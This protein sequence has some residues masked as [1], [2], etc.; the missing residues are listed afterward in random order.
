MICQDCNRDMMDGVSCTLDSGWRVR[1]GQETL[2]A[3]R[4][5]FAAQRGEA[6]PFANPVPMDDPEADWFFALCNIGPHVGERE[7]PDCKTPVGGVHHSGCDTEECPFCH[8][9]AIG[10]ECGG[11]TVALA[12]A[13][14]GGT[15]DMKV[16]ADEFARLSASLGHKP[17]DI[18]RTV[19]ER[20]P[21]ADAVRVVE[22][23]LAWHN[24]TKDR[25]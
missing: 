23:A 19:S 22:R 13:R 18:E 3:S 8:L 16:S 24:R 20:W 21:D 5:Q 7:C 2:L 10:C 14:N 1:W 4:A 9:Q 15:P 25:T 6:E 17:A 11:M 12:L